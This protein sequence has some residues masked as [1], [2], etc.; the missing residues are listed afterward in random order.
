MPSIR[1]RGA[2]PESACRN[3]RKGKSWNRCPMTRDGQNP[4]HPKRRGRHPILGIDRRVGAKILPVRS[5]L[6]YAGGFH[7]SE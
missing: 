3:G 5:S 7:N 6:R 4:A 2:A 1:F